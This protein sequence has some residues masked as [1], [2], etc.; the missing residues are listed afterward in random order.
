MTDLARRNFLVSAATSLGAGGD[1]SR[2]AIV[3]PPDGCV[4]EAQP[5]RHPPSFR[6][7]GLGCRGQGPA[8]AECREHQMDARAV[9]RGH[10]SGRR[11]RRHRVDHESGLVVWRRGR[12]QPARPRVQRVRREAGAGSSDPVRTVRRDAAARRRCH[13]ERNRV[14]L[15]HAEGRRRRPAHQLR[16]HLARQPGVQAGDGRAQPTQRRRPCSPDRGQLL[17][18]SRL[19][20]RR[21]E[22]SS[23]APTRRAPSSA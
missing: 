19:R 21:P 3:G 23:T 5:H 22:A 17:P 15:R 6:A 8:A 7:A 12:D 13:V 18:E 1:V 10:G 16:R 11:R 2:R 4:P 20:P 14:R 9:D